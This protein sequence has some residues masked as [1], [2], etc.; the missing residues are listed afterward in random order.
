[1]GSAPKGVG[2]PCRL[3]VKHLRQQAWSL[4]REG[5][6]QLLREVVTRR[7]AEFVEHGAVDEIFAAPR[8]PYTRA[9]L[10]AVP[11][12]TPGGAVQ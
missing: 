11:R 8:H 10:D 1:M 3:G 6:Y 9:L 5:V 4:F 2:L 7:G 12:L